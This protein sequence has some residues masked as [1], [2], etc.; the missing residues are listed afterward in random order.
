[1]VRARGRRLRAAM[2]DEAIRAPSG[3]IFLAARRGQGRHREV[4]APKSGRANV[5][6]QDICRC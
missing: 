6:L 5:Q 3:T 1:M 4:S 2:A